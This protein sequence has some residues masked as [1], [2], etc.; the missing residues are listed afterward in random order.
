MKNFK[1]ILWGDILYNQYNNDYC[2]H[3]YYQNEYYKTLLQ[4]LE[5]YIQDELQDSFYYQELA[6]SAPTNFARDI[7]L[8]FSKDEKMHA[9]R[10]QEVYY[11]ITGSYFTPKP[12]KPVVI[13]D[14]EDS[15]KQRV[16]AETK[17]YGKY[18]EQ[19]LKA[20]NKYLRYLFFRTRTVEAQHAMRISILFEEE[21]ED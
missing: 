5:E 17:D 4:D 1:T 12:L 20:P 6:K 16:L 2:Y 10:F 11:M 18:G 8:E 14:Y 15:L 7:I 9:Q 19:Y 13:T 21:A 3:D